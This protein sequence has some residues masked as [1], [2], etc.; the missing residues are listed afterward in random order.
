MDVRVRYHMFKKTAV[1]V[2]VVVVVKVVVAD[3]ALPPGVP[4]DCVV[5]TM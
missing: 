5:V 2:V 3:V 1:V 4:L